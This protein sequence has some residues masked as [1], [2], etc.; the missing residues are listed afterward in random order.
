MQTIRI[1]FHKAIPFFMYIYT[2][3]ARIVYLNARLLDCSEAESS[4]LTSSLHMRI[5]I[6]GMCMND[7]GF[8]QRQIY[9]L[10]TLCVCVALMW[11]IVEWNQFVIPM[12]YQCHHQSSRGVSLI[13]T[14]PNGNRLIVSIVFNPIIIFQKFKVLGYCIFQSTNSSS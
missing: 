5:T 2:H 11:S 8:E 6:I 12:F 7:V 4:K 14:E 9:E 10:V 3:Y 1:Q 13:S